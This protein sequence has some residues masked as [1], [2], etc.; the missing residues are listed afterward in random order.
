MGL[1]REGGKGTGKLLA[2]GQ[3]SKSSRQKKKV[4]CQNQEKLVR[5]SSVLSE[6][7]LE[8][9]AVLYHG[10]KRNRGEGRAKSDTG[11]AL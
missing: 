5:S 7:V 3:D 1:V 2:P 8:T 4:G 6:V 9:N 10:I 11:P